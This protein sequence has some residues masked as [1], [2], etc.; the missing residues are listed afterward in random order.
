ME[1]KENNVT[2]KA[3]TDSKHGLHIRR[4]KDGKKTPVLVSPGF[5]CSKK[6]NVPLS[7]LKGLDRL[8]QIDNLKNR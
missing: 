6:K 5:V 4:Y 7:V 8:V 1:Q 2:W 3:Q